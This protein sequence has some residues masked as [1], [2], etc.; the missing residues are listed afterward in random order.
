MKPMRVVV[1][2]IAGLVAVPAVAEDP[3]DSATLI[4]VPDECGQ[5][6]H[7]PGGT[8]SPAAWNQALSFAG[9]MQDSTLSQIDRIDQLPGFVDQLQTAL[10]PALHL[11]TAAVEGGPGPIQLR[12][13]YQI[14]MAEVSLVIRARSSIAVP[15]FA[16][17]A[18]AA[19][20]HRELHDRLEPLL[21]PA[22]KAAWMLFTLIDRA[23]IEDP[24]LATDAVTQNM[25]RTARELAP[26]LG[27]RKREP[28]I[29]VVPRR[30]LAGP[31]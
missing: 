3:P 22:A 2:I 30:V 29:E 20:R 7:I 1:S 12:A 26:L 24:A 16:T 14:G 4:V 23:V 13:A 31:R 17:N 11:Y 21:E 27:P 19:A 18:A 5:Y 10:Q 15:D 28:R 6:W 9:C 25:V 8:G